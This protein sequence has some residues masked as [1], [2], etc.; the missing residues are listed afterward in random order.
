MAQN[1]VQ[2]LA[3]LPW[4]NVS[5][6]TVTSGSVVRIGHTIGIALVTI[7]N[8]ETGSVDCTPGSVWTVPKVSGAVFVAGEK[9]LW[10]ASAAAFDDSAATPATGD[11]MGAVFAF[12][13]GANGETTC[14]VVLSPGNAALT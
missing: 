5:G 13:P 14:Q 4:T 1:K 10:D 12:A 2:D 8:G 11:L 3:I 7:A 9:L 6:S